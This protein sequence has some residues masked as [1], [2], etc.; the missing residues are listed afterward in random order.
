MK[1]TKHPDDLEYLVILQKKMLYTCVSV[2][3]FV[4]YVG[5]VLPEGALLGIILN[6]THTQISFD[7][8]Y[9]PT[10]SCFIIPI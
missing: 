8:G 7:T 3:L 10:L 4:Q 9:Y 5:L 2:N 6:S 1:H